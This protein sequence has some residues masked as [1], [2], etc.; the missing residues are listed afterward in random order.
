MNGGEVAFFVVDGDED[1]EGFEDGLTVGWKLS[2]V[3]S[4]GGGGRAGS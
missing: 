3:P 1:G 2:R 4:G